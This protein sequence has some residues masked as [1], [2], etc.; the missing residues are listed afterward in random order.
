LIET[1]ERIGF[2]QEDDRAGRT[3]KEQPQVER[4]RVRD[5]DG[6][7]E[8]RNGEML[9]HVNHGIVHPPFA[10]VRIGGNPQV[11]IIAERVRDIGVVRS[12]GATQA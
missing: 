10:G 9:R 5:A 3:L 1:A 2:V 4:I 12:H 11:E 7:V 8:V 6:D